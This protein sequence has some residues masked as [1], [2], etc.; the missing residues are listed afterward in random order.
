MR[1]V[2]KATDTPTCGPGGV[3]RFPSWF[4]CVHWQ[5]GR[6]LLETFKWQTFKMDA[7]AIRRVKP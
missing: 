2:A 6:G 7:M 1:M 4:G 5:T 3:G